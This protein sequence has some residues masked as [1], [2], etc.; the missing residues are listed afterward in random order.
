[1]KMNERIESGQTK[2][3]DDTGADVWP[4]RSLVNKKLLHF[5]TLIEEQYGRQKTKIQVEPP[6]GRKPQR[7]WLY[8]RL[9]QI[10][11]VA[12]QVGGLGSVSRF[13][14]VD[15]KKAGQHQSQKT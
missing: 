2:D 4:R 14:W 7:E 12:L 8:I 13:F 1:M 11:C 3:G 6:A 10:C 5:A 15:L 9:K